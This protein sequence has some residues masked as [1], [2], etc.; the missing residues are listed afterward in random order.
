MSD[1]TQQYILK[2]GTNIREN[3]IRIFSAPLVTDDGQFERIFKK[4]LDE[5]EA[6]FQ[7]IDIPD[8]EKQLERD[9]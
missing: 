1:S 9:S 3:L 6:L 5:A 2:P 7:P 4:E 8:I